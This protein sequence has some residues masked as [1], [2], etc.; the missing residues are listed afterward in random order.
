MR[1]AIYCYA[2]EPPAW[3]PAAAGVGVGGSEEAVIQ[4][5]R[6]LA[7]RG[8]QVD[9]V[10]RTVGSPQM[11]E[12]VRWTS[13][14]AAP[15]R[16]DVGVVWRRPGIARHIADKPARGLY[17]WLHDWLPQGR[18]LQHLDA[19]RK[20]M[21]LSRF[22]RSRFPSVPPERVFQTANGVDPNELA[23]EI[24]RDPRLVVYG[25]C[26]TRGLRTLLQ[27]WGAIRRAV[28]GARLNYF[29]GWETVRRNR[30]EHYARVKPQFD[31]LTAQEGVRDLGRISH[32]GVARQYASAGVWAYPCAFPETSC[33]SAMKAQAAGAVPAVIPTG[34]L[35]ETVRH[36]FAT[37]RSYTD[38]DRAP[39][40]RRVIDEW[41]GGLI[42]LL[43]SPERQASIRAGMRAESLRRYSWE[44][45]V[46]AWEGEFATA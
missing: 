16:Q 19:Y 6:R 40:P 32:A 46:S 29:Y 39:L 17:L 10:N 13:Y 34:A 31:R 15:A 14:E 2:Q 1:I 43:R 27:N 18:I 9:V 3:T 30:P 21:V 42:D 45:V 41:L 24:P 7:A 4:V 23:L 44:N 11:F 37:M 26:P 38:Y 5:S 25:S 33:I 12:G 22:H 28:P 8:H 20:V 36:G 35:A